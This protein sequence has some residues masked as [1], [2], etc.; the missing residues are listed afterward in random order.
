MNSRLGTVFYTR[1]NKYFYDSGTG[2]V[3][4]CSDNEAYELGKYLEGKL[5]ID[6]LDS[7]MK[8]FIEDNNLLRKPIDQKF[9]IP[10]K[11]EFKNLLKG[12]CEQII[13]ELTEDCNLRCSYCIYNEHHPDFRGFTKNSINFN[14]AKETIDYLLNGYKGNE[15]NLTFYGGGTTY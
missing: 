9:D 7:D 12:S 10:S 3:I 8:K 2:R 1:N 14:T 6:D 11:E 15:F 5:S 4:N 13:I